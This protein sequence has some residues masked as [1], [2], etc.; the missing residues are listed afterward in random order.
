MVII[1]DHLKIAPGSII[2]GMSGVAQDTEPKTAYF[3][4]P[5]KPARQMHRMHAALE[6]LPDLL[7]KVRALEEALLNRPKTS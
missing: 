5:A 6:Q 3:G 1:K 4:I 2:M 7:A